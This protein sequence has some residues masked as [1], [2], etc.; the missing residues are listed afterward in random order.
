VGHRIV[1]HADYGARF[2]PGQ[3]RAPD[4]S[5]PDKHVVASGALAGDAGS[6]PAA[7]T[8]L[9]AHCKTQAGHANLPGGP[10]GAER[11][12]S[13]G[14]LGNWDGHGCS[15]SEVSLAVSSQIRNVFLHFLGN[16]KLLYSLNMLVISTLRF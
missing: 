14:A 9:R 13:R 5:L 1:S 6:T 11:T 12:N 4:N 16:C 7:S 8:I 2:E 15:L 10:K 3:F